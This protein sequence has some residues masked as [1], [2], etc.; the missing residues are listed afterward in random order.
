VPNSRINSRESWFIFTCRKI[1]NQWV[2]IQ[3]KASD[4]NSVYFPDELYSNFLLDPITS[5]TS[6]IIQFPPESS[7]KLFPVEIL[8]NRKVLI[9]LLG[10]RHVRR[11][12]DLRYVKYSSHSQRS[13][14]GR[15][16]L[17]DSKRNAAGE[18]DR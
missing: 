15:Q 2:K 12:K 3:S 9:S 16:T 8:W 17:K 11:L 7:H 1:N 5:F 18:K 6:I 10:F 4:S 14:K 13:K